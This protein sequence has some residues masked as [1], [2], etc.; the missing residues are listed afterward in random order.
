M[1]KAI[2]IVAL[3]LAVVGVGLGLALRK[4]DKKENWYDEYSET[5]IVAS[6]KEFLKTKVNYGES[7]DYVDYPSVNFGNEV[8]RLV[9]I[10]GRILCSNAFNLKKEYNFSVVIELGEQWIVKFWEIT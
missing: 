4:E 3:I 10:N 9:S 8:E 5:Q 7:L 1:K 6:V 2:I